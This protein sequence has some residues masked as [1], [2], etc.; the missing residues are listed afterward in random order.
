MIA[1]SQARK[2][3]TE[4]FFQMFNDQILH[5]GYQRESINGQVMFL[6][7]KEMGDKNRY[8][9]CIDMDH[10]ANE[11]SSRI[12]MLILSI[13]YKLTMNE[14]NCEFLSIIVSHQMDQCRELGNRGLPVWFI[15]CSSMKLIRYETTQGELLE[16]E[17]EIYAILDL[18]QKENGLGEGTNSYEKYRNVSCSIFLVIL[19][20]IIFLITDY[21]L[22]PMKGEQIKNELSASWMD[23]KYYKEYYRAFTYM[24]LHADQAHIFNNM[25]V[26]FFTGRILERV[27]SKT[28]M[29]FI[30]FGSGIIAGTSSMIYNMLNNNYIWSIGA[31]GAIYGFV[32][33]M[34]FVTL[35]SKKYSIGVGKREYLL[36]IGFSL[37][38]GITASNIDVVAHI[39]GFIAGFILAMLLIQR[40]DK[41]VRD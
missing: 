16:L 10:I 24:F 40:N 15:D 4:M 13:Q 21:I 14:P 37:Y 8:V 29:L 17:E 31:S 30:Y 5:S 11:S 36:F 9:L 34:L 19:N 35:V 6:Y 27:T 2:G 39:A 26:L 38:G 18:Y 20:V 28:R 25:L 3:S 7:R 22:D 12:E 41:K 1:K 23:I 33:A 32:G